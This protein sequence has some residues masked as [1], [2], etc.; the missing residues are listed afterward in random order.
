M[1]ERRRSYLELAG[2]AA[3]LASRAQGSGHDAMALAAS[4]LATQYM[5]LAKIWEPPNA[6]TDRSFRPNA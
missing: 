1:N 3:A 4:I 6:T 5:E 2:E